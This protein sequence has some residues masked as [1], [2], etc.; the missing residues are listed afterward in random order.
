MPSQTA[1]ASVTR[2][3]KAGGGQRRF[4]TAFAGWRCGL[5][6]NTEEGLRLLERLFGRYRCE[7]GTAPL[8]DIEVWLEAGSA[9]R[10]RLLRGGRP[11]D[12]RELL[13]GPEWRRFAPVPHSGGALYS[14]ALFG[15]A[16][17]IE[18]RGG[19][20]HVL[21]P[22]RWPLYAQLAF[23]WLLLQEAPV[24]NLHAAVSA[25]EDRALVLLG[26]SGAGKSTLSWA[27]HQQGADYYGDEW[28]FFTLPEYRQH[29]WRRSLFLRPGALE[30]LDAPPESPIWQEAKPGDPKCALAMPEPL[31]PCPPDRALFLFLDGF[32][33][34]PC[35]AP[36]PG[37]EA[38]RRLLC[39]MGYGD[40]SLMARLEVAAGLVN[41]APCWSLTQGKPAETAALLHAHARSLP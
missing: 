39:S 21:Q 32:A 11:C 19:A 30:A 1:P 24:V 34:T 35:L 5:A 13:A 17:V 12:F 7:G 6:A 4:T 20:F 2:F 29:V 41:H 3:R 26:P 9:P 15:S 25:L 38:A 28:T 22:E 16:P 10:L 36:M 33:E 23:V 37:G 31:R 18:A 14:D 40:P 27:L 8:S